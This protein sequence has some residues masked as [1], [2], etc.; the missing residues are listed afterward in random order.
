MFYVYFFFKTYG[1]SNRAQ[2]RLP[3]LHYNIIYLPNNNK[4]DIALYHCKIAIP[5][6]IC[7]KSIREHKTDKRL[8]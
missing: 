7:R 8:D 1:Q 2:Q 3:I 4:Y 5:K 6:S